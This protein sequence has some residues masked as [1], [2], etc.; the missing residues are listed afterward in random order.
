[1]HKINQM[2]IQSEELINQ[3]VK[4]TQ[5]HLEFAQSLQNKSDQELNFRKS[6]D[7]WNTLECLE[8]LNLYG[9]FYIPEIGKRI[10]S[11]KTIYQEEFISGF[12]GNYFANSMLPKEKL[13]KMKTFKNMNPIHKKLDKIVID[14]FIFQQ[15]QMLSLLEKSRNVN[16]QK[17]K[18]SISITNLIKLK[19]GDTFRI[20]INHNT[21]HIQQIK[22]ILEY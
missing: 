7:S 4:I 2:K 22:N 13:N 12:L 6:T 21:R 1:M 17:V 10:Q 14:E 20:V 5:N 16:L 15:K 8:H 11:S 9:I 19:L 3:L 18:T